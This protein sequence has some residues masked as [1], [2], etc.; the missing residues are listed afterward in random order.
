MLIRRGGSGERQKSKSIPV[1]VKAYE[2]RDGVLGV[3][4]TNLLD[5]EEVFVTLTDRGEMAS[6]KRRPTLAKFR[7]HKLM[8]KEDVGVDPGGVILFNKSYKI[9]D[10]RLVSAW[11]EYMAANEEQAKQVRAGSMV[12]VWARE[13]DRGEVFG[14]LIVWQPDRVMEASKEN[15]EQMVAGVVDKIHELTG[16]RGNAQVLVRGLNANGEVTSYATYSATYNKE[17][18]RLMSGAELIEAFKSTKGFQRVMGDEQAEKIEILPAVELPLSQEADPKKK[19]AWARAY[20]DKH[21]LLRYAKP[22]TY[23]TDETGQWV[24]QAAA[25]EPYGEGVSPVKLA[26][27]G[28]LREFSAELAAEEDKIYQAEAARLEKQPEAQEAEE[29]PNPFAEEPVM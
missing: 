19:R 23:R 25:V 12:T 27:G 20:T 8:P 1:Q 7:D 17:E 6:H 21:G 14:R 29:E 9:D 11:P 16:G 3:L 18:K 5:G 2:E 10:G 22:S 15:A 28:T 13:N 24:V 4:G 26:P